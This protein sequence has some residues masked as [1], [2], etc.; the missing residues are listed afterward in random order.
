[1]SETSSGF[2]EIRAGSH[3]LHLLG[4]VLVDDTIVRFSD[5]QPFETIGERYVFA[6]GFSG[7]K[8]SMAVPRC[9]AASAGYDAR[10]LG[11]NHNH[12][13]NA[14]SRYAD[15]IVAVAGIEDKT[16]ERNEA[17]RVH[18]VGVSMGGAAVLRAAL[19]YPKIA[20]VTA[21]VP[22]CI[23][24]TSQIIDFF[25]GIPERSRELKRLIKQ[26][27]GFVLCAAFSSLIGTVRRPLG[28]IGEAFEL[29]TEKVTKDIKAIQ[30]TPN[31]PH[32]RILLG[33]KD[34]IV[35]KQGV[36]N[37][38]N[39]LGVEVIVLDTGHIN[40]VLTDRNYTQKVIDMNKAA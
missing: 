4:S 29:A 30:A 6:N 3:S 12:I 5:E 21:E 24:D 37:A 38:A 32:I 22:A 19:L 15:E 9:V 36:I 2:R 23:S 18:L 8:E 7:A 39:R 20:T 40:G 1:M 26:R 34:G 16:Q 33:D 27:P 17:E 31:S 11:A 10:A 35:R 13:A 28:F 25:Q 14:I